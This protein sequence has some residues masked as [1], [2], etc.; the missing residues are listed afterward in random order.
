M[1]AVLCVPLAALVYRSTLQDPINYNEG[2]NAYYTAFVVSGQPLYYPPS[3][4]LTNTYPPLSFLIVAPLASLMGDALYAGRIVA[5][6]AFACVT[7]TIAGVLRRIG[8]DWIAAVFG[9]AVFASYMVVNYDIY[10]GMDDP[11]MLAH[12][13]MLLGLYLCVGRGGPPWATVA[14]A[15]L[16]CCGIMTKHN[17][18][19]LPV[20]VTCG[21]WLR[22]PRLRRFVVTGA[23]GML[24]ALSLCVVHYG[25][26]F[27]SSI[28]APRPFLP[29]RAWRH[30]NGRR[31]CRC[32][33]SSP[34]SPPRR[35]CAIAIHIFSQA[36]WWP[37]SSSD[38]RRLAAPQRISI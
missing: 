3:A 21:S 8:D 23:I 27:L 9:A 16:M 36:M 37:R 19:A 38:I 7:L 25:P 14:G 5:W 24:V 13:F 10:V 18:L 1:I 2:W 31:R 30:S 11:Q 12:A 29:I 33:S 6:L 26:N 22:S 32:R 4:L 34:P 35:R 20:T 15:L 17:A 28:L